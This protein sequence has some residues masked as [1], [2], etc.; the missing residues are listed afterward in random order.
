[1]TRPPRGS[2][3]GGWP[4]STTPM[5]G[6]SG[7]LPRS[8]RTARRPTSGMQH[9]AGAGHQ[10]PSRRDRSQGGSTRRRPSGRGTRRPMARVTV[11][12]HAAGYR[13]TR[14][15]AGSASA[16]SRPVPRPRPVRWSATDSA[17]SAGRVHLA[18]RSLASTW[19]ISASSTVIRSARSRRSSRPTSI[20]S[21]GPSPAIPTSS[22][23]RASSRPTS[24]RGVWPVAL[25]P[26]QPDRRAA[27]E[28][29]GRPAATCPETTIAPRIP[30]GRSICAA[31]VRSVLPSQRLTGLMAERSGYSARDRGPGSLPRTS[32]RKRPLPDP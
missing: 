20:G 31:R 24:T 27:P 28:R 30:G 15:S 3:R 9:H 11:R 25:T 6:S 21:P 2:P 18:S 23:Q 4:R 16:K 14:R 26:R 22:R 13:G 17:T 12:G 19:S 8:E 7:R 5:R 32:S 1:M 29:A 10:P